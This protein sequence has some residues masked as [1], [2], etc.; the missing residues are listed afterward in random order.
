M[1]YFV[2]F[3]TANYWFGF[4][5]LITTPWLV[6]LLVKYIILFVGGIA[7]LMFYPKISDRLTRQ[8][9]RRAGS[10]ASWLGICGLFFTF[11]RYERVPLFMY[12]YWFLILAIASIV[13][14][15]KLYKYALARRDKL[16]EETHK[17]NTK[18]KYLHSR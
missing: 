14:L 8:V 2:Q 17:Y 3:F 15:V 11:A 18:E 1:T 7:A 5:P 13:W 10:G 16:N 12:R 4:P 9:V 6:V